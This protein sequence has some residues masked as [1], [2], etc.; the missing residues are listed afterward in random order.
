MV[1]ITKYNLSAFEVVSYR[2]W[3]EPK[4]GTR[5]IRRKM[6]EQIWWRCSIALRRL[7][8]GIG[9]AIYMRRVRT[10]NLHGEEQLFILGSFPRFV[11]WPRSVN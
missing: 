1:L 7:L 5:R 3:T 4:R 6:A 8:G 9:I 2:W 11:L 10:K